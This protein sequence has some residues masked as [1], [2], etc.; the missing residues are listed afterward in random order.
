MSIDELKKKQNQQQTKIDS[1]S[2]LL[3]DLVNTTDKKKLLWKEGY[4]NALRDRTSA[5]ILFSE[6]YT[7]MQ[8]S[9]TDHISLGPIL[10]KYLERMNK[11]NEQL[12]KL[13][14]LISKAEEQ[15]NRIDPDDIFSKISE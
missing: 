3:D 9:T 1:F 6:A 14:D 10:T 12:L 13:A 11:S 2:E 5:E 4:E 15:S 8:V 7:S